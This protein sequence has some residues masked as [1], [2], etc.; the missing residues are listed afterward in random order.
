MGQII[1]IDLNVSVFIAKINA[2]KYL[3]LLWNAEIS[4]TCEQI[5]L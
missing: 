2:S 5:V 4:L 3:G 1:C